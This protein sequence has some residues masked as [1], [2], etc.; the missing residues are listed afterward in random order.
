MCNTNLNNLQ[1]RK[2]YSLYNYRFKLGLSNKRGPAEI[3]QW[4]R[5]LPALAEDEGCSQP[6]TPTGQWMPSFG[7]PTNIKINLFFNFDVIKI[8]SENVFSGDTSQGQSNLHTWQPL[9]FH[10]PQTFRVMFAS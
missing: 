3:N 5:A 6:E 4:S 2:I 9:G 1:G 8:T 10:H 7:I